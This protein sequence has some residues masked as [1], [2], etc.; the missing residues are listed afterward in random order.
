MALSQKRHCSQ[1]CT[2]KQRLQQFRTFGSIISLSLLSA[3]VEPTLAQVWQSLFSIRSL[4]V[5]MREDVEGWLKF[6]SLCR[7]S[8]RPAQAYTM[9]VDLLGWVQALN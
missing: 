3:L 8:G 1:G 9:L 2:L 5:P 4:V 7:K 6:A